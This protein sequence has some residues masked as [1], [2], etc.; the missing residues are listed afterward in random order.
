MGIAYTR[1]GK[2]DIVLRGTKNPSWFNK[3]K[4]SWLMFLPYLW[5]YFINLKGHYKFDHLLKSIFGDFAFWSGDELKGSIISWGPDRELRRSPRFLSKEKSCSRIPSNQLTN[6]S[7]EDILIEFDNYIFSVSILCVGLFAC[8]I[9]PSI[10]FPCLEQSVK[11]VNLLL[12]YIPR[13]ILE[14]KGCIQ[15]NCKGENIDFFLQNPS[16]LQV[17]MKDIK[18]FTLTLLAYRGKELYTVLD[19][20]FL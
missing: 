2:I 7:S 3:Y 14:N 9:M 8:I 5:K 12:S 20:Y 17:S 6:A 19:K 4:T 15:F 10:T 16:E 13:Y 1:W 11:L 18:L